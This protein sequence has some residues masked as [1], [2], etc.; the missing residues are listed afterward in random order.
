VLIRIYDHIS[1]TQI[2]YILTQQRG[3]HHASLRQCSSLGGVW[4]FWAH[5]VFICIHRLYYAPAPV[6]K[7]CFCPSVCPSVYPSVAYIANNSRTQRPSMPKFGK[8]IAHLRCD[9]HTSFKVKRSKFRVTRPINADAHCAPYL[10]NGK[11][12]EVQTWYTNGGRRPA[13]AT[14]ATTSK[15]KGQG[16]KVAWSVWTVL[17]QWPINRKRIVVL[18]PK[19]AP[20]RVWPTIAITSK[21][22]EQGHSSHRLYVSSLY[23]LNS[24]NKMLYLCYYRRARAYRIGQT[25]RYTF[26]CTYGKL[27]ATS[28]YQIAQWKDER[29]HV[30]LRHVCW[31]VSLLCKAYFS[32]SYCIVL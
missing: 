27:V 8:K 32:L 2:R 14:G 28:T 7:G 22:K 18:S 29:N 19:F 1:T 10:P 25:R 20:R 23:L 31:T 12:Y 11:A 16:R 24:G 3:R 17:A 15:V 4:A 30:E 5:V 13:S 9:W 26:C 21:V 6:G